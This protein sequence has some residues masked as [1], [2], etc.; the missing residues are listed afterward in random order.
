[1][2]KKPDV[3][4]TN[5]LLPFGELSPAQFERL[6][7]WLV[8]AEG[9]V[10]AQHLGEAGNDQ[11]RDVIAYRQTASG[12]ELWYFQCKR[13]QT[14]SA[15]TLLEEVEKYNELVKADPAEKP[16][17]VV[18]V[19]NAVLSARARKELHKACSKYGYGCEFWA[20]TELDSMVKKH[21]NIVKEF[22]N[23]KTAP[24]KKETRTKTKGNRNVIIQGD[25]AQIMIVTG[26]GNAAGTKSA[27]QRVRSNKKSGARS[28]SKAGSTIE[29]S[30][31]IPRPP[32]FYAEPAYIGSHKFVGRRAQLET[33]NDWASA[34]DAHPVLL[35]EAIGGNGKS[36]LTWEWTTRHATDIRADW[37]GRFWYSF[38]EKG[39]VMADFCRRALAYITEQPVENFYKKKTAELGDMLLR[40]LQARPW[41]L[42]LDGLERVLVAYHRIDAAQL[43]DEKA[44][45]TDEIAHRDPCSAIRPEDDDLLR[46]LAAAAPSKIL[47]TSR[48]TPRILLNAAN[49]PIPGVLRDRLPGLRP[50]DAEA[51]LRSC[52]ITGSSQEMQ[53]YLQS[54]CDCHPLVTGVLAGLINHYLPNRG[55]FDAWVDDPAGGGLL[56]LADLDLVQ[57]RNHILEFAIG[58]LPEKSRQLLSTLALLSGSVDYYTLSAL[59]PHLPAEPEEVEKPEKPEDSWEWE[60]MYDEE[61]EEAHRIYYSALRRHRKYEA[62]LLARRQSTEYQTAPQELT[63]TVNDLERRGLLQYDAQAQRYDLHPVVRGIAA[64]GLQQE[65]KEYYGQRVVDHF[66]RQAHSPYE[67]AETLDDLRVGLQII[68]TLLQMGH[69]QQASEAYHDDLS[70]ALYFNLEAH[71][72]ALSLLRP[73]FHQG[74]ATLPIGIDKRMA[75]NLVN[76]AAGLLFATGKLREALA[77]FGAS[78]LFSIQQEGWREV[79]VNLSNIAATL[80]NQNRIAKAQYY[81]HFVL[82]VATL[83]NDK[84]SN[85]RARLNRFILL[86]ELGQWEDAEL[87]WQLLSPMG[88]NWSRKVYRPGDA[89]YSYALFRFWQG[90]LQEEYLIHAEQLAKAGR[91]R[92]IIRYL[93]HLRGEWQLEQGHWGLLLTACTK[94]CAWL[95]KL[96]KAIRRWRRC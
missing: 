34:A 86:A 42:I 88:R 47:I 36:M 33:L 22:F 80:S 1:M 65:E 35:F 29:A 32:D 38:Y 46:T 67:E 74:W 25:R 54:H 15:A 14:I 11:G 49:Q 77:A 69:Y 13:Y 37:A 76:K 83:S 17:G 66:S 39:A 56:N 61:K 59:N 8:Q 90:D 72:E 75:S 6:C 60:E 68:R 51:L 28:R 4:R 93:H 9:Y 89:E 5:H 62:A 63:K 19:T 84:E 26:D 27:T 45:T 40:H 50:A 24:A 31:L 70:V 10:R 21:K 87:M 55:N 91:N 41:L 78:L 23:L 79:R 7:L 96:D 16:F 58:A 44:G 2:T 85:F 48:L 81:N 52:G 71:A 92:K 64:G 94:P 30:D 43:V 82:D 95:A 18:F 20:R 53:N 57:K 73:F 12:E 3:T